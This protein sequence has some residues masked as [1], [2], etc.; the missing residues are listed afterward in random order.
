[1]NEENVGFEFAPLECEEV[2][3]EK[4]AEIPSECK[5]RSNVLK[6][7]PYPTNKQS[8]KQR[9]FMKANIIPKHSSSVIFN[10]RSGS[11]KS[12][13]LINLMTRPEFY[14]RTKPDNEKTQ[15]FDIIF[16]FSP[17]ADGGD[18]LV[19]FLKIPPKRIITTMDTKILD[20]II[21]KQKDLI[22]SKG[23]EKSPKILI[24]FEDIQSNA[25]KI[26]NSPSFLKC[27]IQARH[28]NISTFLL[29]QSWT[30][31]PRACRLQANNIFFFP[32]SG[33][34]VE[35]LVKE[36]CPPHTSKKVFQE[37]VEKA[38]GDR[39]NFLHINMREPPDTR[40][41][42]N[43]DTILKIKSNE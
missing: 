4:D 24:I 31:T 18:D 40:F 33:S 25:G 28:L 9:P 22:A 41:R 37:L 43:L 5:K 10:G 12:N 8:I 29:G 19:R 7:I 26:M 6:I 32:S 13:L 34:E 42:R 21:Q 15:Y 3:K 23:L 35:L 16:L 30:K 2:K 38:T 36:F 39:Y 11:G 1:M 14:G 27:F 20:N 17:T